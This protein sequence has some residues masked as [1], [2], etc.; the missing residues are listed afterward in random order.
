MCVLY[1]ITVLC[2][3]KA[4]FIVKNMCGFWC[5]TDLDSSPN[6]KWI[7]YLSCRMLIRVKLDHLCKVLDLCYSRIGSHYVLLPIFKS[8]YGLPDSRCCGRLNF[9][10]QFFGPCLYILPLLY[11]G[12]SVFPCAL[13]LCLALWLAF[14]LE[15]MM[16]EK[17]L[18]CVWKF[19]TLAYISPTPWK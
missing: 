7:W 11:Y 17:S 18:E 13:T 4:T 15:C 16:Q 5:Q 2:I 6:M 14:M 8:P 9:G 10:V 3:V 12:C 19:S 1:S